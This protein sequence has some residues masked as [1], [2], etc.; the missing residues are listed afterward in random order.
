[1]ISN[2][3]LYNKCIIII[4]LLFVCSLHAEKI[5]YIAVPVADLLLRPIKS[6]N[7]AHIYASLFSA[8]P[9]KG[10][11]AC[12]RGHQGIFNEQVSVTQEL[13]AEVQICLTNCFFETALSMGKQSFYWTLKEN[14]IIPEDFLIPQD[15]FP[16][17]IRYNE[18]F[19]DDQVITLAMP[20]H[21]MQTNKVYSV[22][23]RFKR[24]RSLDESDL[25]GIIYYDY[26]SKSIK[27][28]QI[29]KDICLADVSCL[30][31]A[32]R[33]N[34]F[35]TIL[36]RWAKCSNNTIAYVWGGTSWTLPSSN[37]FSLIED[38]I[39]D[40]P[41]AY[42]VRPHS[43]VPL[44]GFDCSGLILRAAQIA[45]LP[46]YFKNTTTIMHYL[47]EISDNESVEAGDII[48]CPGH[49]MIVS[50]VEKNTLVESRGYAS[51]DGKVLE[52]SLDKRFTTISQYEALKIACLNHTPLK[53]IGANKNRYYKIL[54]LSSLWE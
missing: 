2:L 34:L 42:W 40:T 46:Y 23:T 15:L 25:F 36:R 54:K 26:D 49:V 12:L 3:R 28:A 32:E 5:G 37:S 17:P 20:W 47:R 21:D 1:M 41:V 29:Q 27:I 38:T 8:S 14:I 22:G 51:G 4:Y 53:T 11:Y 33:Q 24:E 35:V 9:Q 6:R 45:G 30:S 50:D 31:L 13:D 19:S 39:F 16:E 52:V 10:Q 43:S 48:W 7:I 44:S 18:Y